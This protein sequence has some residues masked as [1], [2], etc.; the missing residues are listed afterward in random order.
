MALFK[1]KKTETKNVPPEVKQY[2]QSEHRERVGLA[3]LI[4]FLSLILT[5][6]VV[7]GLFFG[8][9][10]VYRKITHKDNTQGTSQGGSN[11]PAPAPSS[12]A[13][14]T[15][16]DLQPAAPSQNDNS[17]S[18]N[19]SSNNSSNSNS[20]S[21]NN[22]SSSSSSSQSSTSQNSQSSGQITDTGPGNTVLTFVAVSVVAGLSHS[23]LQRRKLSRKLSS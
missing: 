1:R 9:R 22:S 5:I 17:S 2:Y 21:S 13:P 23:I 16:N 3:W 7:A 11:N 20:N 8:G 14:S 18:N 12:P 19:S 15:P 4:A 6:V 10:W